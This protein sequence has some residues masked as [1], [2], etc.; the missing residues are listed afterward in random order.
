MKKSERAAFT[1]RI[2]WR[3][4]I[5]WASLIF[6]LAYMVF[7]GE[8]GGGDSRIVT[9]LADFVGDNIFFGG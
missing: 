3:I 2:K 7:V 6:M 8:N 1:D 5:L 9:W 4:R